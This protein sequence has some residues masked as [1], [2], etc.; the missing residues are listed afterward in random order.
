M[1]TKDQLLDSMRHETKV[2]QHLAAK[3][4]DGK[5]DYRPSPV[6]RSTEEL[7]RY[8]TRMA[9]VPT[10]Y[11]I[12]GKWDR[13]EEVEKEADA[14]PLED[15]AKEMDKQMAMIEVELA[16]VDDA[17]ATTKPAAMPWGTPT[18]LSAGL[19]DMALKCFV[20]YRMQ[21]FLYVKAS[22]VYDI[23][24]ANCWAGVDMP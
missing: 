3:V 23:G 13:A 8:M 4:P 17:E 19:M 9:I 7:L 14:F 18:A 10:I 16:A 5:L 20:A 2:I 12:E 11:A 15:F 1:I 6:Q 21:L 24:P 22:G